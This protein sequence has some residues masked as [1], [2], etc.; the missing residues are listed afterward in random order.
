[1]GIHWDFLY[2]C[3][4][5]L[6]DKVMSKKEGNL[7]YFLNLQCEFLQVNWKQ[8]S[9][10]CIQVCVLSFTLETIKEICPEHGYQTQVLLSYL[11]FN[12]YILL[13]AKLPI[14]QFVYGSAYKNWN[15][16]SQ[17]HLNMVL[18]ICSSV[19]FSQFHKKGRTPLKMQ[20][21]GQFCNLWT[22]FVFWI[23]PCCLIVSSGH[24][25]LPCYLM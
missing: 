6:A 25:S 21:N 14:A 12:C 18:I 10:T 4:V 15:C 5:Y 17:S 9:G 22:C 24:S 23:L 11:L 2:S 7:S 8:K 16:E 3:F 19:F 1:M 13:Y 20:V